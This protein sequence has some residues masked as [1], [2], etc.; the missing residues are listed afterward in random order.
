M[1]GV[2]LQFHLKD[3]LAVKSVAIPSA[4]GQS[5]V[6]TLLGIAAFTVAFGLPLTSSTVIGMAMSVASTVVLMRVLMDADSLET[7][8]VDAICGGRLA[9]GGGRIHRRRAGSDSGAGNRGRLPPE[10]LR[11]GLPRRWAWRCLAAK[12]TALGATMIGIRGNWSFRGA[13]HVARTCSRSF[14]LTLLVLSM[15][16]RPLATVFGASMRLANSL[17]AWWSAG[18]RQPPCGG[19]R[20]PLGRLAVLFF[21]LGRDRLRPDLLIQVLLDPGGAGGLCSPSRGCAPDRRLPGDPFRLAPTIALAL[22]QVGEFSFIL[23]QHRQDL[24]HPERATP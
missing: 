18:L 15:G 17:P 7:R 8:Q 10:D 22:A 11:K 24:G 23:A 1:F 21:R 5:L 3:L 20:P 13:R 6:A 2:G 14:T 12:M 4:I 9:A 16:M 19:G